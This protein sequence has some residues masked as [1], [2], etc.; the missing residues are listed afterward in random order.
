[1]KKTLSNPKNKFKLH[2]ERTDKYSMEREHEATLD[3]LN[4]INS[5]NTIPELLNRSVI[6]L[7]ELTGVADI[8]IRLHG[9]FLPPGDESQNDTTGFHKTDNGSIS[10]TDNSDGPGSAENSAI[11]LISR[12]ILAASFNPT[13]PYFTRHGSFWTN[14]ASELAARSDFRELFELHGKD[15]IPD[16]FESIAIIPLRTKDDTLGLVYLS[17]YVK[18]HFT[19]AIISVLERI[20]DHLALALANKLAKTT[21]RKTGELLGLAPIS[22]NIGQWSWD[23]PTNTLRVNRRY[24]EMLGYPIDEFKQQISSYQSLVHTED[25]PLLMAA[26]ENSNGRNSSQFTVEYRIL[27]KSGEWKWVMDNGMVREWDEAN[28]PLTVAGTVY[29]ITERKHIEEALKQSEAK[30]RAILNAIPDLVLKCGPD[31]VILD[32]HA[33]ATNAFLLYTGD[34]TGKKVAEV[35]SLEIV[36]AFVRNTVQGLLSEAAQICFLMPVADDKLRYFESRAVRC[37]PDEVLV[38]VRDITERKQIEDEFTRYIS[39]LEE[40]K[41]QIEKQAHDLELLIKERANILVQAESANQAK[42]DFLATMSHEIRTPMNSIIGMSEMLL[43]TNLSDSQRDYTKW[44]LNSANTLLN[45]VNDILD[46]SKVES[47]NM[48]IEEAP[49]DLRTLCEE[50]ME[51]LMPKTFGK[52]IE[53]I[54]RFPQ[55]VPTWLT[56]D[57]GRIRQ[58]LLNLVSN[59]IKFT[60]TGHV[61]ID[62]ECLEQKHQ[63]ASLKLKVVDTGTGIPEES[64][65]LLFHKFSQLDSSP[66]RKVGGTGLGLAICKSFIDLMGGKIG[67]ESDYGRGSTFWFTLNLPIDSPPATEL[68]PAPELKGIRALVADDF[69]LGRNILAEYLSGWGLRCDQAPSGGIALDMMKRAR[70]ENDPY[71]LALID[72]K[73]EGDGNSDRDRKRGRISGRD[74]DLSSLSGRKPER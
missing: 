46:I 73:M 12:K 72:Q 70:D 67:V 30:S 16:G 22:G 40:S 26:I 66:R 74:T 55:N 62:V 1:M 37:G 59:A 31:G 47:G 65:P 48:A 45:I 56:G 44:I 36:D 24:A 39:E 42:S 25:Y 13:E 64:L 4:R 50:V 41:A 43:K 19:G 28:H 15:L 38:I 7:E 21:P 6:F 3:L 33:S 20:V 18:G 53:F 14:S 11:D 69:E 57:A 10:Q 49:F 32:Y 8:N 68:K 17:D 61:L 63:K 27:H 23:I 71:Q 34:L 58:I 2:Q 52:E 9:C 29:D 60:E 35:F 5:C 54:V 51:L